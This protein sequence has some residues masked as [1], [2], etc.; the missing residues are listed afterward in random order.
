M[1]R[2][3]TL[4]AFS[5]AFILALAGCGDDPEP[6]ADVPDPVRVPPSSAAPERSYVALGDSYTAAPLITDET[7]VDGCLRSSTNYPALVAAELG[8]DL[9]DVSCSGA[10]TENLST[11]QPTTTGE[12]PPQLDALGP[13][14]A[15]VTI[16]MGGNDGG[17]FSRLISCASGGSPC[18]DRLGSQGR[19]DLESAVDELGPNLTTALAAVRE[20]APAAEVVVVGYPQIIAP[21]ADCPDRLPVAAGDRPYLAG[22]NERIHT[23]QQRAARAAK[24]SYVDLY[25]ASAGHDVC[26]DDPW[27][28]GVETIPGVG[29]TLHPLAAGQVAAAELVVAALG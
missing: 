5:L 18:R 24:A 4:A 26:A 21:D 13:D 7:A 15:L 29:L 16:G 10:T 27:V 3:P 11:P 8:Y 14:T 12:A 6:S 22:L 1:L 23:V 25:D 20:Q 19:A 28:N 17:V 2:R 9:T